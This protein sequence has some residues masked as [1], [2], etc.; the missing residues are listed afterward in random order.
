MAPLVGVQPDPNEPDWAK[1]KERSQLVRE[2]G[3][4]FEVL[5][6]LDVSQQ[7]AA[8]LA[9]MPAATP[10]ATP[11]AVATNPAAPIP[12]DPQ[13]MVTD[14]QAYHN[15]MLD[16]NRKMTAAAVAAATQSFG[17]PILTSQAQT[18]RFASQQDTEYGDIW[19]RWGHEIDA[20]MAKVPL[21]QRTKAN[22]DTIAS[23][24]RGKHYKELVFDA[25]TPGETVIGNPTVTANTAGA[26]VQ[27]HVEASPLDKLFEAGGATVDR[28]L[29]AGLT[30]NKIREKLAQWQMS[31]K[32]WVESVNRGGVI[33]SDHDQGGKQTTI[34][35]GTIS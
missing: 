4:L 13:L 20:K 2:M 27:S 31:E 21:E 6:S 3:E 23:M 32:E 25:A 30:K 29:R 5:P 11:A 10:A 8:P 34:A 24:V 16:Y 17:T 26:P 14:S 18:A 19:E 35:S 12:P 7:P 33:F 1:G 22:Y 9:A 15:Q 28:Y